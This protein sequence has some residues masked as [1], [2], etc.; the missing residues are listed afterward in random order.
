MNKELASRKILIYTNKS[1]HLAQVKYKWINETQGNKYG[2]YY[3]KYQ[4]TM[5][6]HRDRPM[7]I[8]S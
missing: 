6:S 8:A 5:G 1:R 7:L 3:R 4:R 2:I